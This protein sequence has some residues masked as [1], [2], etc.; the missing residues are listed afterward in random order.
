MLVPATRTRDFARTTLKP[1][2]RVVVRAI[3]EAIFANEGPV[4]PEK[5]DDFVEEMDR[6]VSPASKTLR[7]GLMRL[8]ELL[9]IIPPLL[10]GRFTLFENL[11][12]DD[13]LRVF[14]KCEISKFPLFLLIFIAYKTIM[15]IVW[16]EDEDE[17][18]ALGYPGPARERYKRSLHLAEESKRA[19]EVVR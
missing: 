6:F 16:F 1:R 17:L 9:T 8:L 12:I 11:P 13:R 14:K 2:H 15:A 19:L 4:A 18:A 3:A 10:I 5:L 7:F